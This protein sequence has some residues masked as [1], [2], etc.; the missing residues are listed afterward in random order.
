[1]KIGFAFT[2][3]DLLCVL[4]FQTIDETV[5]IARKPL[6]VRNIRNS[7][8]ETVVPRGGASINITINGNADDAVIDRMIAILEERSALGRLAL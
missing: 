3:D 4:L 8:S 5:K 6:N 1:M 2:I 7:S